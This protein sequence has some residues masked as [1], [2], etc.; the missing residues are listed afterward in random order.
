VTDRVW[1]VVVA[2]GRGSRF[3]GLKQY[4]DLG[5]RRV[6]DWALDAAAGV[7]AGVVAVVP[8]ER[9]GESEPSTARA[10]AGGDT[11]AAS[12]RAGL[13]AVPDAAAIVVVH[14]AARPFAGEHLF[15][16][17]VEA[18]MGGADGAIPGIPITDTV[19]RVHADGAVM[20][21]IDRTDLVAAQTPQAF[22]ADVLRNAHATGAEATDDAA[23]VEA[24]GGRV[25]VVAGDVANLKITTTSDL[26]AARARVDR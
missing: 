9:A 24:A 12:V 25:V 3:G 19:K 14:D 4:E 7:S 20:T 2:A 11:R 23:L 1:T 13:A 15:R 21:T 17:V 10:V 8:P 18:V 16:A 5:G 22:R 26:L 6:L